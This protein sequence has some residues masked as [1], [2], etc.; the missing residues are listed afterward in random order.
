MI[1]Q[2]T[3]GA[4]V[5]VDGER[6]GKIGLG[7]LVLLGVHREDLEED[8]DWLVDR[9][10]KLR[11]FDDEDGRMN[12][13]LMD[14]GGSVLLVSQFTLYG[15]IRKGNRPSYNRSASSEVAIPLYERFGARLRASGI[16]RVETGRFGASMQV[17]FV[18]DGPVTLILDSR[19]RDL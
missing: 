8:V 19:E 7:F 1:V 10:V 13:S 12:R 11:V 17:D 4:E 14:I 18:N 3:D 2:R 9:L 5:R 15:S 6:V 16:P